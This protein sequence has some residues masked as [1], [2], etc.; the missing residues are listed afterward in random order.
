MVTMA[1][2][3]QPPILLAHPL[4]NSIPD[5]LLSRFEPKYV[6][7][8]N[9]YSAGRL[10]THQVPI[11]AYRADPLRY[12]TQYGREIID[13]GSLVITEQQCPVTPAIPTNGVENDTTSEITIRIFQPDPKLFPAP[14]T[15]RPAYVNFHG[16]GWVF[17]GLATDVDFCK[18]LCHELGV[19]CF[20]VDYRLAP[21][22]K[23]PIPVNDCWEAFNWVRFSVLF[24][25]H[26]SVPIQC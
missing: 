23:F 1:T 18:R 13:T 16:G 19:V 8:Y 6:E 7:Y 4:L 14:P 5:N 21:E 15:G 22:Y 26:A 2:S 20:D 24:P 11:E 9:K 10:A 25:I 17:G 12:T 3:T